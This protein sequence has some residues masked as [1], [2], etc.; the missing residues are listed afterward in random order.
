MG[1]LVFGGMVGD[2]AFVGADP[3]SEDS[4]GG[5]GRGVGVEVERGYGGGEVGGGEDGG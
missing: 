2:D 1:V 5:G 4:P 3:L